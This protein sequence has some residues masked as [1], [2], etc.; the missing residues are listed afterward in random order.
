MP[1]DHTR[2]ARSQLPPILAPLE[3]PFISVLRGRRPDRLPASM[4]SCTSTD[5]WLFKLEFEWRHHGWRCALASPELV[6]ELDT[7]SLE[8]DPQSSGRP[9][10]IQCAGLVRPNAARRHH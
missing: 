6:K 4:N 3:R 2:H 1:S 9:I 5:S 10:E 8:S 7:H